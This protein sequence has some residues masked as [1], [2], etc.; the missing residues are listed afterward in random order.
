MAWALDAKKRI[1]RHVRA[2]AEVSDM[3]QSAQAKRIKLKSQLKGLVK[4]ARHF[5]LWFWLSLEIKGLLP[6]QQSVQQISLVSLVLALMLLLLDQEPVKANDLL[7]HIA[8]ECFPLAFRVEESFGEA[9]S[10]DEVTQH[11]SLLLSELVKEYIHEDPEGLCQEAMQACTQATFRV[12]ALDRLDGRN[13]EEISTRLGGI[14]TS[15]LCGF[16]T[17]WLRNLAPRIKAYIQQ[18]H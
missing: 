4:K 6:K 16:Y 18:N 11:E 3:Q 8:Y 7:T 15:S 1:R 13:W 12:I 17:K 10:I 2:S 9:L 5:D 14:P